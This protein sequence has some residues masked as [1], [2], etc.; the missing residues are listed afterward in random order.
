MR[1]TPPVI[2][3]VL[4]KFATRTTPDGNA[5]FSV[6]LDSFRSPRPAFLLNAV[7]PDVWRLRAAD[8]LGLPELWLCSPGRAAER[9]R[10]SLA[11]CPTSWP[12]TL[13]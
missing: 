3:C 9:V 6:R 12:A 8:Y 2:P 13:L 10:C 1:W 11:R 4:R 5:V 7:L